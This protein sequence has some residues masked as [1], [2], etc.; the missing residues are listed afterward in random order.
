M[1][2]K[3]LTKWLIESQFADKRYGVETDDSFKI[4]TGSFAEDNELPRLIIPTIFN[5][6]GKDYYIVDLRSDVRKD[7]TPIDHIADF[8]SSKGIG[9]HKLDTGLLLYGSKKGELPSIRKSL[10]RLISTVIAGRVSAG[11][12]LDANDR[13]II[14]EVITISFLNILF[15][16]NSSSDRLVTFKSLYQSHY[17]DNDTIIDLIGKIKDLESGLSY[18]KELDVSV[19]LSKLDLETLKSII[20]GVTYMQMKPYIMESLK[21]PYYFLGLF[22]TTIKNPLY[23]K[24]WLFTVLKT[25]KKYLEV[26]EL[27]EILSRYLLEKRGK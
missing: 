8:I 12:S 21:D 11:I 17:L 7:I 1:Y 9:Y 18:L 27:D 20:S 24:S 5:Y 6:N 25:N 3:E 23:K 13:L 14:L 15:K 4:I 10:M 16:D 2:D 22:Y 26:E 19:R